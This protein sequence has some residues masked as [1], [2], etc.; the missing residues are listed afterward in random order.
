[1]M[2]EQNPLWLIVGA[3]AIFFVVAAAVLAAN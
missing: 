2:N 1:M 3:M